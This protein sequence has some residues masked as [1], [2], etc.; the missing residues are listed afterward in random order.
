MVD[1]PAH[2]IAIRVSLTRAKAGKTID[3][4]KGY[5]IM[6][7]ILGSDDTKLVVFI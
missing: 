4:R 1:S 5:K 3:L 7:A 6:T 2:L